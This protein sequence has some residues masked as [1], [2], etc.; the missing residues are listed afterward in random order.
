M[1]DGQICRGWFSKPSVALALGVPRTRLLRRGRSA[2]DP[3]DAHFARHYGQ[4]GAGFRNDERRPE[5]P[6]PRLRRH[7]SY[8][9]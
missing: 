7:R 8:S 2:L 6:Q 3:P 9:L 5:T 1:D 4:E